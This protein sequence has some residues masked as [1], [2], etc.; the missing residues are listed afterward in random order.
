MIYIM[1][2]GIT[3]PKRK[4]DVCVCALLGVVV[5]NDVLTSN[6]NS[7]TQTYHMSVS[8]FWSILPHLMSLCPTIIAN[9]VPK[10]LVKFKR[11]KKVVKVVKEP[12]QV[13]QIMA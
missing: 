9:K 5:Y 3:L 6:H 4:Y 8:T 11:L 12:A 7:T 2:L 10:I 1:R 13:V